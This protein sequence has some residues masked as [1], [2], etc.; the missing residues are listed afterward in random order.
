M[1]GIAGYFGNSKNELE[2]LKKYGIDS[3]KHRGPDSHGIMH[4][5]DQN[6]LFLHTRLAIR[7]LSQTGAQPMT[8]KDG[9]YTIIYNGELYN[10]ET[11]KEKFLGSQYSLR[12]SADTEVILESFAKH[13]IKILKDL[14][15]IF[16]FALRDN[17]SNQ[18]YLF[19]DPMG[20][21]P[22][23]YIYKNN[24]F[25]FS[26]EMKTLLSSNL[27]EK[28]ININAAKCHVRFMWSPGEETIVSDI[29]KLLPGH[30]IIINNKKEIK[31]IQYKTFEPSLEKIRGKES[32][33]IDACKEK[34]EKAVKRQL[35][36]DVPVGFFLSGGVDSSA[37]VSM[38]KNI[39]KE[40]LECFTIHDDELNEK[41]KDGFTGDYKYAKIMADYLDVNL[42]TI[43]TK[44]TIS[45]DLEKMIYF[46]DEP[47]G[48]PACLNTY[49]IA[50]HAKKM[51]ISVLLG[52][53]GADD[54]FTGYRRHTAIKLDDYINYIPKKLRG[55]LSK[56]SSY[57]D[58]RNVNQRRVKKYLD[59]I[60]NDDHQRIINYFNWLEKDIVSNLF[61]DKSTQYDGEIYSS[62][63][64]LSDETKK[65][66]KMLHIE[67]LH[68]LADHNLNYSDKMG[69]AHGVE[70]RVPYLDHDLVEFALKAPHQLLQKKYSNKWLLKESMKDYI[71]KSIMN[72]PKTGFG[73]PLR[74]WLST[75]LLDLKNDLL[76]NDQLKKD[77]IFDP[78]SVTKLIK[79]DTDG[80]IDGTYSIFAMMCINLWTR[81]F[82]S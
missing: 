49:F 52:G 21:K 10:T 73:V 7:D 77:G 51:G 8:S 18:I 79:D 64:T 76:S 27:T 37:I 35:V 54:I 44:N 38:S 28:N 61:I 24:N 62:I 14:N 25:A 63:N 45:Q 20:V 13:G 74:E 9:R 68:F 15:G 48:D 78:I 36:S 2:H 60:Q 3:I 39:L 4:W 42:N 72:R 16:A 58:T 43:S 31:K 81:K 11:V 32:D 66:D 26:S 46:M 47:N 70:I 30:G 56:S 57:L 5:E 6:C 80:Y 75:D 33:I 41:S 50:E 71:P 67:R 22:L 29:K 19:R 82:K 34:I 12:G 53:T 17:L 65:L 23:Y 69:M 55:Y 59:N 40:K 1:C